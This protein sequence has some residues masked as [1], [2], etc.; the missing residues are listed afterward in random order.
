[1]SAQVAGRA[2]T[3]GAPAARPG[4]GR[5]GRWLARAS[6]HRVALTLAFLLVFPWIAPYQALAVN[7]LV[8]GL[9]ALGFNLLFGYTGLLSF[10]HAAF[11]GGGAYGCG[12]AIVHYGLH[13]GLA[14]AA[15]TLLATLIAAAMG[16][17]A[18]RTRGIYFAMTTLALSM[19]VYYAFYRAEAFTGGENGLRGINVPSVALPGVR[20]NLLDPTVKYYAVLAVVGLAIWLFSRLLSSPF[21]AAL[22]AIRE[23]EHRAQACGYD[24]ARMKLAAFVISGALCGLAGALQAI[25]L[26]IVPIEIMHYSTSGQAV[27]MALLGGMGTF[28]GP[29]V[30]AA[31]FSLLQDGLAT[32]TSHWQLFVGAIFIAFVLFLPLGIWGEVL[33]RLRRAGW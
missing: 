7:I 2:V 3:E 21:G 20:L 6:R 22:E 12:I 29:F 8:L 18:I 24:V 16:V 13:P 33:A 11:L 15:G 17:L 26:S 10:G 1:M 19:C 14:L 25:H 31:T 5:T 32:L 23:N 30:G 4:S 27:M 28:F 9:Y